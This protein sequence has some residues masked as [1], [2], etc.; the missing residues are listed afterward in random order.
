MQLE[1]NNMNCAIVDMSYYCK[2]IKLNWLHKNLFFSSSLVSNCLT[3]VSFFLS[4]CVM[5][6]VLICIA[7]ELIV[8]RLTLQ[9]KMI[10]YLLPNETIDD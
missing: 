7:I 9:I 2:S 3:S 8:V 1:I 10:T 6:M 5:H 4:F